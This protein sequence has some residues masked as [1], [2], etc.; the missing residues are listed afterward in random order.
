MVNEHIKA[1]MEGDPARGTLIKRKLQEGLDYAAEVERLK[2]T[3]KN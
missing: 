3:D 1:F 2:D